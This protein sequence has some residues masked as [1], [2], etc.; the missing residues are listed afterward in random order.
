[1]LFHF[2]LLHLS[3]VHYYFNLILIPVIA[4]V[5]WLVWSFYVQVISKATVFKPFTYFSHLFFK[6]LP[7]KFHCP[8]K[9]L[10]NLRFRVQF[11][12]SNY[13]HN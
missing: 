6:F 2:G 8:L 10:N 1:M 5:V 3:T 12:A 4:A 9:R 11:Y 7:H 13:Q